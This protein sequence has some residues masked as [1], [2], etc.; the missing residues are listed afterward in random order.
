MAFKLLVLR[1]E[2][3]SVG[4]HVVEF[5]LHKVEELQQARRGWTGGDD[6]LGDN[7]PVPIMTML[8]LAEGVADQHGVARR[9]RLM[10]C[11]H[12]PG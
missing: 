3:L 12:G 4:M 5:L 9:R 10:V 2:V 11:C 8:R 1:P 7:V 6:R